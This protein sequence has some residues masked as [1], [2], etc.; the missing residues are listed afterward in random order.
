MPTLIPTFDIPR[1]A[2]AA[3]AAPAYPPAPLYDFAT[4]EYVLDARGGVVWAD[5]WTAW[6]QWCVKTVLTERY[7]YVAYGPDY[8][9]ELAP[10]LAEADQSLVHARLAATIAAALRA[11]P[12]T[13]SVANFV[14]APV[15]DE[16]QVSFTV[17][18]AVGTS[19]AVA[20]R[21]T[22]GP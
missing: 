8:G 21:Y 10:A 3:D 13:R 14:F 9:V 4:G 11:D 7:T 6:V 12:R 20:L 17:E 15:G 16:D 1:A 18:P 19:A 5:G 2:S 22:G